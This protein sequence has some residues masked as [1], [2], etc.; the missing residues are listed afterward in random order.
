MLEFTPRANRIIHI[1]APEESRRL[2][3]NE[4]YPEHLFL[5]VLR[6]G[7]GTAIH[8]LKNLGLN[9]PQTRQEIELIMEERASIHPLKD[10][11]YITPQLQKILNFAAKEAENLG[12]SYV[13]TEHLLLAL[14][15]DK[16]VVRAMLEGHGINISALRN[17]IIKILGP[18][19]TGMADARNLGDKKGSGPQKT[20]I[21]DDFSRDLTQLAREGKLDPVIG[22]AKEIE[23]ITQILSRRNKNNP[24]IIG[25]PGVGKTAI[26]E[27][28]ADKIFSGEVPEVLKSKRLLT[29][30]LLGIV[31]GTKYRGEFEDRLKKIIKEVKKT[32]NVILFIDELHT[33]IGAGAAEG[34]LDA[35]NILKPELARGELQIIGATTLNEYKKYIEKDAALERRFQPIMV[36]EPTLEDSIQILNGIKEKYED[37][38]KIRY[39]DAAIR[40]AVML[41]YRYINDRFLPDKAIDVLDEAGARIKLQNSSKPQKIL[42]LEEAV[43]QLQ[44]EKDQ[45]VKIQEFEK[46]A[47]FRDQVKTLLSQLKDAEE[48]WK[49]HWE[50]NFPLVGEKEISEIIAMTTGVP[51]TRINKDESEKLLRLEEELHTRV[52]G[53]DESISSISRAIRRARAGIKSFKRPM[54]SFLFLGPTGVG[55]TELAKVLAEKVFDREDALIRFDMSDFMEK[56]AVA[57]LVGAPPGYVGY[58]EGGLLTEAI[59]RKPYSVILFDEVEKAHPDIFNILLQVMEEGE[60]SDNLG[61][62]VNFRNTII[63]MTSNI[64]SRKLTRDKSNLGFSSSD[65]EDEKKTKNGIMDELKG[66]FN[67]EFLNRVDDMILFHPLEKEQIKEIIDIMIKDLNR[68]L[69]ER[70][71]KIEISSAVKDFLADKGYDKKY[72]ARPLRRTIQ[73]YIEDPLSEELLR[74]R[75]PEDIA[76]IADLD[77]ESLVFKEK[78]LETP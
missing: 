12:H 75:Y 10:G 9:I 35:A 4:I 64:G 68:V 49:T 56:H 26:V 47:L 54:G 18:V 14:L 52:I 63:I 36:N 45:C 13:G 51:V 41:S 44:K 43:R 33:I 50:Q 27:G 15:R 69:E 22:R 66:F 78:V 34:A 37:H 19:E 21:L 46:A 77:G 48:E 2:G 24:V 59:R 42:E 76:L 72:G 57:R 53:Q 32:G 58:E 30:D 39:S 38:H 23:R 60:L 25:E 62:R 73:K 1:I 11:P 31:A 71:L 7:E 17:E 8:A 20:P 67:P 55:K 5:A 16:G 70:K 74:N 61:H 6:E 40:A 3:H 65:Q 28:L 29:I